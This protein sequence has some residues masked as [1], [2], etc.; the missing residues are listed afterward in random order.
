MENNS[1]P[2]CVHK[3]SARFDI[4]SYASLCF[5]CSSLIISDESKNEISTIKPPQYSVIQEN[6]IPIFLLTLNNKAYSYLNKKGY[7]KIR[8]QIVKKMKLLCNNLN[9]NNK[10]FFLA[11][12]YLDHISSK[13]MSF[14]KD[15]IDDIIQISKFCIILASKFQENRQ[16]GMAMKIFSG[17]IQNN[18]VKDELFLLQL[19]D[20]DLYNFTC[21][22]ILMDILHCGFLFNGENF[23]IN[24]MK[25]IYEKIET[26]LYMFTESKYYIEMSHKEIALTFIGLTREILG[27]EPFNNIIKYIFINNEN[28][29]QNYLNYLN[30]IKRCFVIKESNNSNNSQNIEADKSPNLS[31]NK[32]IEKEK[33]PDIKNSISD[34]DNVV[35]NRVI[36]ENY[37]I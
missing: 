8:T 13:F 32:D 37:E 16:K 17:D 35:N 1:Q 7:I 14:K 20:Y 26:M 34:S 2:N 29:F 33:S 25:A 15:D 9:L 3:L 36:N 23:S 27:L 21:Y 12:D 22:D 11:L 6:A 19:L 10:T 24:K 4:S 5:N 28:N 30:L 18:Y 31:E